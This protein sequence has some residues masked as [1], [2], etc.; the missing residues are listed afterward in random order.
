MPVPEHFCAPL[1]WHCSEIA[2]LT[3]VTYRPEQPQGALTAHPAKCHDMLI[4][5]G[6]RSQNTRA[7]EAQGS[8][9][10]G[11]GDKNR[12]VV[13]QGVTVMKGYRALGSQVSRWGVYRGTFLFACALWALAAAA[14]ATEVPLAPADT[15]ESW[16]QGG[17]VADLDGD[18]RPDLAIVRSESGGLKAFKYR[19]DVALSTR[20]GSSSISVSS[21]EG[22]LR[23][24]PR[25]VDGNGTVDLVVTSAR[26]F[27]PVGI[28]IND[29][30]G[31]F[32]AGDLTIYPP[33]VWTEG[34][35]LTA[36]T[37][38]ETFQ[39]TLPQS[40][41]YWQSFSRGLDLCCEWLAERLPSCAACINPSA[42]AT[43]S[44]QSRA[45]PFLLP[46]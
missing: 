30:H 21:E 28:Y 19:I 13:G 8:F 22:G 34:A 11:P 32:R 9:S 1:G 41:R 14:L 37:P 39:A 42:S 3:K 36:Q 17:A 46:E 15:P 38:H 31:G 33:T 44:A 23:I 29:G 27:R 10:A 40:S 26:R 12:C 5:S 24:T 20:F 35:G 43:R 25:D 6:E 16:L 2:K 4:R 7:T 18:G 45:P